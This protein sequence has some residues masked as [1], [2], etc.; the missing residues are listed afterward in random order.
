M[1][2]WEKSV[3]KIAGIWKSVSGPRPQHAEEANGKAHLGSVEVSGLEVSPGMGCKI[4]DIPAI[5][6]LQCVLDDILDDIGYTCI[7]YN[8]DICRV[9]PLFP[10][11]V[12]DS[13]LYIFQIKH[14]YMITSLIVDACVGKFMRCG[15]SRICSTPTFPQICSQGTSQALNK[16]PLWGISGEPAGLAV[17]CGVWCGVAGSGRYDKGKYTYCGQGLSGGLVVW[18]GKQSWWNR[19]WNIFSK[20]W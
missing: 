5:A 20:V 17:W 1:C 4:H 10:F 16:R 18:F 9:H 12:F 3:I 6:L 15:C 8:V 14:D 11:W 19:S 7:T 2:F 13:W